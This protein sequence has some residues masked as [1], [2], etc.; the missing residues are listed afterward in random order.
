MKILGML[1]IF[2]VI[3]GAMWLVTLTPDWVMAVLAI[4][5]LLGIFAGVVKLVKVVLK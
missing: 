4:V 5:A 3:Y 1:A 2:A